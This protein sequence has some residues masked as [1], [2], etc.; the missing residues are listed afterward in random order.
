V[1]GQG[2]D[3]T[4]DRRPLTP[5]ARV[6]DDRHKWVERRRGADDPMNDRSPRA[7]MTTRNGDSPCRSGDPRRSRAIRPGDGTQRGRRLAPEALLLPSNPTRTVAEVDIGDIVHAVEVRLERAVVPVTA[8]LVPDRHGRSRFGVRLQG[9]PTPERQ[10]SR[11]VDRP[12]GKRPVPTRAAVRS[13]SGAHLDPLLPA[14]ET[15]TFG[16]RRHPPCGSR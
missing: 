10:A 14:T 3:G 11:L 1:P 4:G 13:P 2:R 12:A 7:P 9:E 6:G 15:G 8:L 5:A 16:P